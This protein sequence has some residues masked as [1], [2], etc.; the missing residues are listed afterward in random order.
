MIATDEESEPSLLEEGELDIEAIVPRESQ[1]AWLDDPLSTESMELSEN[2][3]VG[4]ISTSRC[5]IEERL[6]HIEMMVLP[7]DEEKKKSAGEDVDKEEQGE[8]SSSDVDPENMGYVEA[9]TPAILPVVEKASKEPL[10]SIPGV[11]PVLDSE[12][13]SLS[14]PPPTLV[15]YIYI[16]DSFLFD[17]TNTMYVYP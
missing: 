10:V 15:I 17:N 4:T 11:E 3:K 16:S 13:I 2:E 8:E 9:T 12:I 6:T 5:G 1:I 7:C 14:T